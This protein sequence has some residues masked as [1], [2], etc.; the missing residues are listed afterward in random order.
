MTIAAP[1]LVG[2]AGLP[3]TGKSTIARALAMAS[4]AVYLRVDTIEQAIRAANREGAGHAGYAVLQAL[5]T[6]NLSLGRDV[7]ADSVNPLAITRQALADCARAAG[8]R[9]LDVELVCSNVVEHRRRIE[10]RV[11]EASGLVPP[12]WTS[13]QTRDYEPWATPRIVIDTSRQSVEQAVANLLEQ[14]DY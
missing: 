13:V 14:M 3:G 8:A 11:P 5:A 12:D 6:E 1:I 4:G 2:L 7:I 9:L 10:S